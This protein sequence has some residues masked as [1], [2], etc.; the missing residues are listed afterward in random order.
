MALLKNGK[1]LRDR[2]LV[3][4][5]LE[6][7]L[8]PGA[9]LVSLELWQA[10]RETL[11]GLGAVGVILPNDADPEVLAGDL[12][13]IAAVVLQFPAFADGRA[14]SQARILRDRHGYTGE[15]R[16]EGP[17]IAD[18]YGYLL[19]CGFDVVAVADDVNLDSWRKAASRFANVYQPAAD[20]RIPAYR[21]RHTAPVALAS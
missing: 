19:R 12:D 15:I 10:E 14:F 11:R 8:R 6:E 20:A 1:L 13:R 21:Q 4:D 7:A 17:L 2:W 16:A 9:K 18:Q 5:T 3:A